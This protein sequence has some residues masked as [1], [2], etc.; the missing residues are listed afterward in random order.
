MSLFGTAFNNR[1]TSPLKQHRVLLLYFR[2][3]KACS[4]FILSHKHTMQQG[5]NNI[6]TISRLQCNSTCIIKFFRNAYQCIKSLPTCFIC[7]CRSIPQFLRQKLQ[8]TTAKINRCHCTQQSQKK[9]RFNFAL[10]FGVY[11]S[12]TLVLYSDF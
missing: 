3:A 5:S 6:I 11:E 2:T 7:K 10:S 9:F 8:Q 12:A 1:V 4:N